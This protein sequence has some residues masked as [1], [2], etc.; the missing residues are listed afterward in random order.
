MTSRYEVWELEETNEPRASQSSLGFARLQGPLAYYTGINTSLLY[1]S[2]LH[3]QYKVRP[4]A[5]G[6]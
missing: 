4:L 2:C 5:S 3:P 1:V 6:I